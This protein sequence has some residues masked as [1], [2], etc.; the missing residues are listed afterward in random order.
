MFIL[1]NEGANAVDCLY[2]TRAASLDRQAT[3]QI[4]LFRILVSYV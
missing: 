4:T 1:N 3:D 2:T